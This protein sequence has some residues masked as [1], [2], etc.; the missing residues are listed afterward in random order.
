MTSKSDSMERNCI[1]SCS[2]TLYS[3]RDFDKL[4]L[5]YD[6]EKPTTFRQK[7][8]AILGK[9]YRRTCVSYCGAT[10]DGGFCRLLLRFFCKFFA[11]L[12]ILHNYDGKNW[13]ANDLITGFTIGVMHVPQ[14]TALS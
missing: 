14:G 13:L 1:Q 10:T 11:F 4:Y 6:G 9:V 3:Q 8:A 5:R 12:E 2:R 7:S